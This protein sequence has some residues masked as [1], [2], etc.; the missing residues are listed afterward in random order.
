MFFDD[1]HGLLRVIVAGTLACASCILAMRRGGGRALPKLNASDLVITVAFSSAL[2][3]IVISSDIA[4]AEGLLA[5]ALL[6]LLQFIIS[7]LPVRC[8][9]VNPVIRTA[10]APLLRD[11]RRIDGDMRRV[12]LTIDEIRTAV[13][14]QRM[15]GLDQ[16]AAVIPETDGSLS[17]IRSERLRSGSAFDSVRGWENMRQA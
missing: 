13:R 5:T 8:G 12:R 17:I 1:M 2:P 6:A 10:P 7:W 4:L 16:V 9:A 3:F 14:R 11:G 15:G